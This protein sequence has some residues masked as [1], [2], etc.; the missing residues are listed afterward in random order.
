MFFLGLTDKNDDFF[1]K[2]E[3]SVNYPYRITH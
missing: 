3:V 1:H 2:K